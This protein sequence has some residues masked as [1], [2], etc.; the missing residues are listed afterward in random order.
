MIRLKKIQKHDEQRTVLDIGRLEVNAGEVAAVVGAVGSGRLHLFRLLVGQERPSAGEIEV[1]GLTPHAAKA[2]LG[3]QIG[4]VFAADTLYKQRSVA[5]NLAF[6]KRLRG[7]PQERVTEVLNQ[8]GLADQARTRVDRLS[9]SLVRRLAFG[10]AL[11]HQPAVLL[12]EE[13]FA[14]CDEATISL[15]SSL[16]QQQAEAKTAVLILSESPLHLDPLCHT[17]HTLE[18]GRVAH[19]AKPQEEQAAAVPFKIPVKLEDS[20]VLINPADILFVEASGGRTLLRTTSDQ[21]PTQF[22]LADLESRLA[23]GG[24]FRAHR[25]YL[26]NLQHVREVISYTRSS[27]SLKLND[28]AATKIPLSKDAARELREL[29]DF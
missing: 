15:L 23:R 26:V 10:V 17:I 22:T 27:F 21:F 7:L 1:A 18:Q 9:S 29:L 2:E 19:V 4:V 3:Q 12:L 8:V 24:F 5:N 16:I 20:V 25:S 14:R 28:A 13:P 11:L 6:H